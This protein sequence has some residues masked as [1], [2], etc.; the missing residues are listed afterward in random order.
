MAAIP[1]GKKDQTNTFVEKP[2]YEQD[3]TADSSRGFAEGPYDESPTAGWP[4]GNT[5]NIK[6]DS[7]KKEVHRSLYFR[8]KRK[9][10]KKVGK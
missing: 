3:K 9:L 10:L 1:S 6:F 8:D 5:A 7:K 4:R 2:P